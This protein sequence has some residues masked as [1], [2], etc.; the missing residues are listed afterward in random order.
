LRKGIVQELKSQALQILENSDMPICIG[1]VAKHFGIAW[2]TARQILMEL[3]LEGKAECEK[4]TKS[5]I[6]KAKRR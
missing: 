4:T 5:M 1:D 2:S 3:L 6:F